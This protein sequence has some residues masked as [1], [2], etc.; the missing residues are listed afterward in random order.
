MT[1]LV[2][3]MIVSHSYSI[4]SGTADMVRQMCGEKI[5]ISFAG[6][7][8]DGKIGTDLEKILAG[9]KEIWSDSGVVVLYD[10]GSSEMS[11]E[12]AIEMLSQKQQDKIKILNAPLVEGAIIA[13]VESI[14]GSKLEEV[15]SVVEKRHFVSD[16]ISAST[17]IKSIKISHH[18]GL[19][20]RPAVKFTKLAKTFDANIQVKLQEHS[21]WV[22]AKSIVKV[23]GLKA[24]RGKVLNLKSDGKDGNEAVKLL[25]NFVKNNFVES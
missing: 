24:S 3:I 25:I 18:I 14:Q 10:L 15:K 20:A 16:E 2:G 5:P 8:S 6:G 23:M 21:S 22:N 13:G 19:H 11:S 4:A 7:T 1:D 17:E 12:A 9:L